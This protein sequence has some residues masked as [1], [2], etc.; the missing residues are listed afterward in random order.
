MNFTVNTSTKKLV[1]QTTLDIGSIPAEVRI[2]FTLT[3]GTD[4]VVAEGKTFTL[5]I[6]TVQCPLYKT[7][8]DTVSFRYIAFNETNVSSSASITMTMDGTEI[9]SDTVSEVYDIPGPDQVQADW[10]QENSSSVAYIRHKPSLATV[11]TS[12][13][14]EDL[15][16]KPTI[17][18]A[19]VQADWNES[20]SDSPS[21]IQHKPD[22]STKLDAPA[23]AGTV[24]QVLTMGSSSSAEWADPQGGSSGDDLDYLCFTA[25]DYPDTI[26]LNKYGNPSSITLE[27]STDKST[28]IEFVPTVTTVT[29]SNLGDKVWFRGNNS[30][31]TTGPFDHWYFRT[32]KRTNVDGNI[33]SLLDKTCKSVT[34][35][36]NYCFAKLFDGCSV[37]EVGDIIPRDVVVYGKTGAFMKMLELCTSLVRGPSI[38]VISYN[39]YTSVST[40]EEMYGGCTSLVNAPWITIGKGSV[41]PEK[42]FMNLFKN[43]TALKNI[44]GIRFEN[45]SM[46]LGFDCFSNMFSGCTA[47]EHAPALPFTGLGN[48]CYNRMFYGCT[49]LKEAPTLPATT[50]KNYCYENMF[51]GC[52]S[53]VNAPDLPGTSTAQGCYQSMFYGCTG[54]KY[55]KVAFTSWAGNNY[56][57]TSGWLNYASSSGVFDCPSTLDTTTRDVTHVPSGW[58]VAHGANEPGSDTTSAVE[59]TD[60]TSY[61]VCP[62]SKEVGVLTVASSLT[63]DAYPAASTDIAYAEVVLDLAASATVTAGSNLTLVDTPT[64]GQRNICVVRWSGGSARL[65][66]TLTEDLPSSSSSSASA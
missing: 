53:L 26:Q 15:T 4:P 28:W 16:N 38:D 27:Y 54:L 7:D 21:Y 17:P 62:G 8:E 33:M 3:D 59:S 2:D 43:C 13:S 6:G 41:V 30:T 18:A 60:T 22:L 65:Y 64:D 63:L 9:L 51:A 66:V 34:I 35:P 58:T 37:V 36:T 47:L 14:Y 29:L 23:T 31:F 44:D 24:G 45:T 32:S 57:F 40:F 61:C 46:A 52:T 56:N 10:T 25:L 11:A 48:N 49:S 39:Y 12:G 19:Q 5:T 1:G 50:M 20:S 42:I 55:L